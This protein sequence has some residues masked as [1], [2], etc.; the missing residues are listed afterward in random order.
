[1]NVL[2]PLNKLVLVQNKRMRTYESLVNDYRNVLDG[3][4]NRD[5]RMTCTVNLLVSM[6]C[7]F[8]FCLSMYM[9]NVCNLLRLEKT[10]LFATAI[11][12]NLPVSKTCL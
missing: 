12:L 4:D 2:V 3:D 7:M 1:M 6:T 11:T 9:F 8:V 5:K 10:L